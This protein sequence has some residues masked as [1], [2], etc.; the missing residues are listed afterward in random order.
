MQRPFTL[1]HL[2]TACQGINP[3]QSAAQ[4]QGAMAEGADMVGAHKYFAC[5]LNCGLQS[6][7]DA[8]VELFDT[9]TEG[10]LAE[11]YIQSCVIDKGSVDETM[12]E[13][14]RESIS[15]GKIPAAMLRTQLF[16]WLCGKA[17]QQL[18]P[19]MAH[20]LISRVEKIGCVSN[21]LFLSS[22]GSLEANRASGAA[23]IDQAF[24]EMYS[25]RQLYSIQIC[26]FFSS[27]TD[28]TMPMEQLDKQCETFERTFPKE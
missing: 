21:N 26:K 6:S 2:V 16:V 27:H 8:I 7:Y 19:A 25:V 14:Q 24:G 23:G 20:K 9:D 3:D 10:S 5:V 11:W 17:E 15:A 28:L 4:P 12:L 1:Q 22:E 18:N 13:M